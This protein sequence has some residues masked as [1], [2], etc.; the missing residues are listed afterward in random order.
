MRINVYLIMLQM[1]IR[2]QH[3]SP[4]PGAPVGQTSP[5]H[6]HHIWKIWKGSRV[7]PQTFQSLWWTRSWEHDWDVGC[8][9]QER[10]HTREF[11][12]EASS[13]CSALSH[14][15]FKDITTQVPRSSI[16]LL[17]LVCVSLRK[18]CNEI[19]RR[20]SKDLL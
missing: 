8:W 15:L 14:L 6:K 5:Y 1:V 9:P 13:Q 11:Q 16:Q 2:Y 18:S 4:V 7:Q 20:L 10:H 19:L 3:S 17:H 12:L